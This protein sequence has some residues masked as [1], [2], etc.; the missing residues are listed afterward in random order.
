[1]LGLLRHFTPSWRHEGRP[2]GTI[3]LQPLFSFVKMESYLFLSHLL[4]PY[5]V[6]VKAPE[7]K[8]NPFVLFVTFFRGLCTEVMS[9]HSWH[10]PICSISIK[11][12]AQPSY[13]GA[14]T[15]EIQPSR[16][17]R[18]DFFSQHQ[19]RKQYPHVSPRHCSVREKPI[20]LF[21]EKIP[22]SIIFIEVI[23]P[24][25]LGPGKLCLS[26]SPPPPPFSFSSCFSFYTVVWTSLYGLT[27][28]NPYSTPGSGIPVK[29]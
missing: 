26:I 27:V 6:N 21:L 24:F 12:S 23:Q 9:R 20:R 22:S 19:L 14:W 17:P 5:K 7:N 1:M 8:D 28:V 16:S 29:W 3:A 11:K 13:T 10:W 2:R 18:R 25:F 15:P 4:L